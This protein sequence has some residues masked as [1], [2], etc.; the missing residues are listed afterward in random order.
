MSYNDLM[1]QVSLNLDTHQV[2]KLLQKKGFSEEQAEGVIATIQEVTL[3]G[4]A[5]KQD[6]SEVRSEIIEVRNE[7]KQDISDLRQD[8][9]DRENKYLA[10]LMAHTIAI[11]GVMVALQFI[12]IQ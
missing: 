1:Q 6:I 10:F 12:P 7:L 3:S 11:I 5:T 9:S 8:I 2:F 4:V